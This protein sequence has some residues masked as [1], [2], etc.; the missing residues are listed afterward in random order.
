MA[1]VVS[2]SAANVGT[3]GILCG[4]NHGDSAKGPALSQTDAA[5]TGASNAVTGR[6]TICQVEETGLHKDDLGAAGV[7]LTLERGYDGS[8]ETPPGPWSTITDADGRF[9][10]PVVAAG[11]Y[12]L[13]YEPPPGY[14]PAHLPSTIDLLI[15]GDGPRWQG[16]LTVTTT[17]PTTRCEF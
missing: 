9:T 17:N 13:S 2:S 6:F 8:G 10:F 16:G 3:L 4:V 12:I 14:A 1:G 11:P 7:R 15:T 5:V